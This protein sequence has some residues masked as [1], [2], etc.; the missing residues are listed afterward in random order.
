M[1]APKLVPTPAPTPSTPAPLPVL[2]PTAAVTRLPT[3]LPTLA[4]AASLPSAG[5]QCS[6][7]YGQCGGKRWMGAKCCSD[8]ATCKAVDEYYSQC[9]ASIASDA[10]MIMRKDAQVADLS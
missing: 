3:L 10:T 7:L 5:T 2:Q 6:S 9:V 4:P 8:Q 1:P